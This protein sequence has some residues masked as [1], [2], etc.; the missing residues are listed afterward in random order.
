MFF[1]KD[2]DFMPP[3]PTNNSTQ[4]WVVTDGSAGMENQCIGL[5]E[6]MGLDFTVK[7]I[8]TK[9]PWRWLPPQLW[10]SPLS[11]LTRESEKLGAPW[12]DILITCGR[13]A[14]PMSIAIRKA[15]EKKT[16]TVHIQTPNTNPNNFDLII[17][18]E[19]DVL[20]AKNVL[21]SYGS[22]TRITP[23]KLKQEA[24]KFSKSLDALTEPVVTV[25]VGGSNRCYDVT[26]ETMKDLCQKLS[27]LH[28]RSNCFFLVTTSRRT[29]VEN[30]KILKKTLSMLPHQIWSGKG[31]NP[32]F[33]YLEKSDA[34]IVTADS[35][36]MVCEACS[37]GKPVMVFELPGGNKKFNH[38]HKTMFDLD[39]TRPFTGQFDQ[40]KPPK[41]AETKRISDLVIDIW[42]RHREKFNEK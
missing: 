35:V 13:Q 27:L 14:I 28:E 15:S 5:A 17:V 24:A 16:F 4:C 19:H 36:N 1:L 26:P 25:L 38:F 42:K 2:I 11:Q 32:Y 6:A 37:S 3:S 39:H 34:I 12:P 10:I 21:V 41:L 9:K 33:A 31:S 20:R 8:Q 23:K 7:R 18:P 22:L 40:W 30:E 29:G